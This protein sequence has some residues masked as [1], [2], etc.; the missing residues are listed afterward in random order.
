MFSRTEKIIFSAILVYA[1]LGFVWL[2]FGQSDEIKTPTSITTIPNDYKLPVTTIATS[3]IAVTDPLTLRIPVLQVKANI[4]QVGITAKGNMGIPDNY[5]DAGWLKTGAKPGQ[6]GNAVMAGHLDTHWFNAG[7]FRH[8][9]DL[10]PG[11]DIYVDTADGSTK[12]FKVVASKVYDEEG[13]S[14]A[15]IFGPANSANLNLITCD[16]VWNQFVKRYN[17]RLVVFTQLVN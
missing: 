13:E 10:K 7:V 16:G 14:L 17:Q 3:S 8:L 4:Q 1:L 9:K 5:T 2:M 12:H 11:D 15:E 6:I